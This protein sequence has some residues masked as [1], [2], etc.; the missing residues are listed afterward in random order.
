MRDILEKLS[1]INKSDN[2]IM[3]GPKQDF[4]ALFQNIEMNNEQRKDVK[5]DFDWAY[6]T[7]QDDSGKPNGE[8]ILWYM[9]YV[10]LA[11][12]GAKA[13][14]SSDSSEEERQAYTKA[15]NKEFSRMNA[16]SMH[17]ITDSQIRKAVS[18]RFKTNIEHFF[19]LGID[20]INNAE[21]G[22]TVP[23]NLIVKFQAAEDKWVENRRRLVEPDG[24]EDM[25]M[26]FKDG[27]AWFNLGRGS[28][29]IEGQAMGHC[30]NAPSEKTGDKIVSLR[31]IIKQKGKTFHKPLLTFILDGD[32]QLGEMK[33]FA[34]KKPA[35]KY[36]DHIVALLKH[37]SINGI[38]GGGHD[39]ANNFSM[40]DLDPDVR[41]ELLADK[42]EL[43][44]ITEAIR[45]Q[46][47]TPERLEQLYIKMREENIAPYNFKQLD[48]S[49]TNVHQ[50]IMIEDFKD[51][52]DF[53]RDKFHYDHPVKKLIEVI[54][55]PEKLGEM[56]DFDANNV[57]DE[58]YAKMIEY[59]PSYYQDKIFSAAGG[60]DDPQ[61]AFWRL[62]RQG[63][64]YH[65]LMVDAFEKAFRL[66][67]DEDEIV[68]ELKKRVIAYIERTSLNPMN[69]EVIIESYDG[70]VMLTTDVDTLL[71]AVESTTGE[72]GEEFYGE[73]FYGDLF[74][75]QTNGWGY[76]EE[77]LSYSEIFG[78]YASEQLTIDDDGE[79]D[80]YLHELKNRTAT[81]DMAAA[82]DYFE[83]EFKMTESKIAD[84]QLKQLIKNIN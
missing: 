42:P 24:D 19:S 26:S 8:Q 51:V 56:G 53:V 21:F 31:E 64:N 39:P 14:A 12:L 78:K 17:E 57:S 49:S 77:H 62:E 58:Y 68:K 73:E 28:C 54:D 80:A 4:K 69:V 36:H 48:K 3:E 81:I 47:V 75:I 32:N 79:K 40:G 67:Q 41:D 9:R 25:I 2:I 43:R 83:K 61:R 15:Y 6:K 35:Q 45:E 65:K 20:A 29:D 71:N 16:K 76:Q 34:N 60:T 84:K 72:Y 10:R 22:W 66:G 30:G 38:K 37:P 1:A 23:D 18:S 13:S 27:T 82:L 52:A 55:D 74:L 46:G 33:G 70:E 7:F 44:G 5:A 59:L 63:H 11:L 50:S